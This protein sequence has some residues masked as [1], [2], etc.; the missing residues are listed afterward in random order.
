MKKVIKM[1][2]FYYSKEEEV[3]DKEQKK[4]RVLKGLKRLLILAAIGLGIGVGVKYYQNEQLKQLQHQAIIED[5]IIGRLEVDGRIVEIA[6]PYLAVGEDNNLYWAA[7]EGF[8]EDPTGLFY[9]ITDTPNAVNDG[10]EYVAPEG[11]VLVG[12][13]AIDVIDP[14]IE[15]IDGKEV[16]TCP[17]GYELVG[18]IGVKVVDAQELEPAIVPTLGR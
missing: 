15:M 3:K 12:S 13:K 10:K 18:L 17:E 9:R 16:R 6:T 1:E 2:D 5:A 8:V 14:D 7:P 4:K 11:M